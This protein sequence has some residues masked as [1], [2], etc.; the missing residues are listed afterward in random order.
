MVDIT[1]TEEEQTLKESVVKQVEH[2][3][4]YAARSQPQHH[5]TQLADGRVGQYALD[6]VH[7]QPY[8]GGEDAGNRPN[9]THSGHRRFR[10]RKN[11]IGAGYQKDTGGYHSGG[12]D[13]GANRSRTF[14]G[15]R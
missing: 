6:I 13:K 9:N 8:A 11:G 7:H 5:I 1:R 15:V 3:H 14:H 4:R 10:S 2:A 12:V